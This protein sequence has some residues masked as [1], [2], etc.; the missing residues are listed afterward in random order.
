V[1]ARRRAGALAAATLVG[2]ASATARAQETPPPA[3]RFETVV[4]APPPEPALPREDSAAAASVV[5][6]AASPRAYDDL[7]TLLLEVPGVVVTRT[8]SIG[9]YATLALRGSSPDEVRVYVDGVPL[10][11]AEGGGVDISTLPVG[12][13]ERVEVYR[14]SSPLAFGGSALG[15]VVSIVTRTPGAP[16]A[17]ARAGVA[18]FGTGYGDL[19]AGGRAGPLRLYAGAHGLATAGRYPLVLDNQTATNPADDVATVRT[20]NDVEQADGVVRAVADL[21]GRRTLGLGIVGFGRNQGLPGGSRVSTRFARA[22]TTRA[23]AYAR[24]DS[25]DDLGPGG[26]LTGLLYAAALREVLRDPD[27]ELNEPPTATRDTTL[28]AGGRADGSAPL[29]WWA[30]LAAVAEAH[31]ESFEPVDEAGG[32]A[33]IGAPARRLSLVGGVET[34]LWLRPIDL[35]LVP[36]AR[37]EMV[38]DVVAGRNPLLG[39]PQPADPP[40]TRAL[41]VLRLALVR[42]FGETVTVKANLGRYARVPSFYELYGDGYGTYGRTRGNPA[43]LPE[44]GS[45]ADVGFW[46][47]ATRGRWRIASRTTAF[48]ARVDDLIGWVVGTGV[49]RAENVADARVLGAEQELRLGVGRHLGLVAQATVTDARAVGGGTSFDGRQL[50]FHP[51]YH[52]YGRAE[53]ARLAAGRALELGAFVDGD[54]RGVGYQDAANVVQVPARLLLGAGL[55][56][57]VPRWRLRVTA[58]GQN[59]T[60]SRALDVIS[61]PLPGR[62]LFVALAWSA[63]VENESTTY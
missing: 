60:D 34:D 56:V 28:S 3:R 44:R 14:G 16:Y 22:G 32:T 8:G 62:A 10:N 57:N 49:A 39:T 25:R 54:W 46:L 24:Y 37:L 48:G 42:P 41:P 47:D 43:L 63:G 5:V 17:S 38:R 12:D 13:V 58:S 6:P 9:A 18:S 61:M 23:L 4:T 7:T 20:N 29:A 1:I 33:A 11:L 30:R 52:G 36:S 27:G 21:P 59:L 45:N 31:A 15:G 26:R 53:L 55:S 40:I 51:R 19:A 50:P 35:H 2:A